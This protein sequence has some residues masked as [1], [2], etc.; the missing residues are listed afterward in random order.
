LHYHRLS[1]K[2]L[3]ELDW[4][5]HR[6]ACKLIHDTMVSVCRLSQPLSTPIS[7]PKP[8]GIPLHQVAILVHLHLWFPRFLD[9]IRLAVVHLLKLNSWNMLNTHG[10]WV[11]LGPRGHPEPTSRYTLHS[12]TILPFA[13]INAKLNELGGNGKLSLMQ[14]HLYRLEERKATTMS[15][16]VAAV[17]LQAVNKDGSSTITHEGLEKMRFK[18]I[19]VNKK[20]LED[21]M[22]DLDR[23]CLAKLKKNIERDISIIFPSKRKV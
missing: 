11:Q 7:P 20:L 4:Q 21:P 19:F 15:G 17:V 5:T 3:G 16:D 22:I 13:E 6:K 18:S 14:H 10:F 23:D 1:P 12:F 9:N 2:D 8:I